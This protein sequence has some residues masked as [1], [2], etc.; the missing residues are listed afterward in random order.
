M[1]DRRPIPTTEAVVDM[2]A[3]WRG[4]H[5]RRMN[6]ADIEYVDRTIER[7]LCGVYTPQVALERLLEVYADYAK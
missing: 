7:L 5:W 4:I 1:E 2:N 6:K 3:Y